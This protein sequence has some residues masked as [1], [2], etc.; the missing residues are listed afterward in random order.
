MKRRAGGRR[1]SPGAPASPRA[2][3]ARRD[4]RGRRGIADAVL[5]AESSP[6]CRRTDA[7]R[8]RAGFGRGSRPGTRDRRA[9]ESTGPG[10]RRRS[11]G[12]RIDFVV[13]DP[14]LGHRRRR[15]QGPAGAGGRPRSGP[16]FSPG[17][18]PLLTER[19]LAELVALRAAKG[20]DLAFLSFRPPEPGDF[21]R[22]V[23]DARGRVQPDRRGAGTL[24]AER[25]RSARST[26]ASTASRR[27]RSTG[28]S[29]G[30]RKN[31]VGGEY[32]LTD[33]V[34]ILAPRPRKSRGDRG[35]GLARGM[36]RQHPP[37]SRRGRG[38][39]APP[40]RRA[41]ARRR[42]DGA[43]SR[44]RP[45]RSLRPARARRD[46]ASVRVP[47]GRDGP[48][49]GV[50]DLL[51]HAARR[52]AVVSANA[53][54]GPHCESEKLHDRRRGRAWGRSPA[55]A[56]SRSSRRTPASATS[57]RRRTRAW[58]RAPRRSTSRTSGD[59][60]VG[61][62]SNIGAGRHHV[63]LRRREEAPD[64]D[65]RGRLRRERRAARRARDRRRRRV[66]RRPARRSPQDVPD[67]ALAL[68]RVPQVNKPGWA[69]A[70]KAKKSKSA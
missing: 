62:G 37:G 57:S 42:R 47:R 34:E 28:L 60:D 32:Y 36:G 53:A 68:S 46:P 63:Q 10:S 25:R 24:G 41:G 58:A 52:H 7:P 48:R 59:A 40:R 29:P 5:P 12:A 38:D 69:A 44:D 9:W 35:R 16:R 26:P 56:R 6:P 20:L 49:G 15:P 2:S 43:R 11:P 19:T 31:P 18:T 55:C 51:L 67:G 45:H 4:S 22:V 1:K 13:Q 39:R 21:G 3:A 61:A 66:R 23:R 17:D 64:E 8:G 70:R 50:R 27:T 65:R 54:V 14:P 30:S 33:A